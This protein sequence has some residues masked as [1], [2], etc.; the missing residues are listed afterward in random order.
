ML[1]AIRKDDS[2]DDD[3]KQNGEDVDV[4]DV[5]DSDNV[6]THNDDVDYV[7]N[8]YDGMAGDGCAMFS[9]LLL[10]LMMPTVLIL[11]R[12]LTIAGAWT[13]TRAVMSLLISVPKA[14]HLS[15]F[16]LGFC[17]SQLARRI[18]ILWVLLLTGLYS[19]G[20][21]QSHRISL[22]RMTRFSS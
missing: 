4:M 20:L 15:V 11:R 6:Y 8:E 12:V 5:Q 10:M 1:A 22:P 16:S 14:S 13:M 18:S 3:E 2:N 7:D 9:M 17:Q 19:V 21:C